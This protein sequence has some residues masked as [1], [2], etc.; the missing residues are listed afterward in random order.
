MQLESSKIVKALNKLECPEG[1]DKET[2][3]KA[4]NDFKQLIEQ[5]DNEEFNIMMKEMSR[6]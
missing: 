3:T 1:Y 5:L 4:N 2:W 6:T